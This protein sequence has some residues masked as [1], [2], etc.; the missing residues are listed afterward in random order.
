[1]EISGQPLDIAIVGSGIAG[2]TAAHV[3]SREH[4]VSVFEKN[5]YVG[6]H[7]NTR[8]V[9][10][11]T[12]Q[13]V[14]IDTGFIVCNERNYPCF[15]RF[16]DQLDVERRN[17]DMSFG[18]YCQESRIGYTGP[19]ILD[20]MGQLRNFLNPRFVRML[21]ELRRFNKA[22]REDFRHELLADH[23]LLGYLDNL[24]CSE[25][26]RELYLIPISA[27]IWSSP[28]L[29]M[30]KFPAKT[31]VTFLHH[32]GMLELFG[33]P[34]WQTI[35]GGS[36]A[37]IEAFRERFSGSIHC[38][39]GVTSLQRSEAGVELT[40]QNGD[41]LAFDKVIL[42]AHADQSCTLLSDPSEQERSLLGSWSY[43]K[44]ETVL[45]WDESVMPP[46]KKLWA[47]WNYYR[48]PNHDPSS[49]VPITYYMNRLQGLDSARNYF[50]TLNQTD[51]IDPEKICYRVEYTHPAYDTESVRAQRELRALNGARHTYYCGSYMGYGFHE[52]AVRSALDVTSHFGLSL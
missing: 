48:K 14:D 49:P 3:L 44:N 19:G 38:D 4:N 41:T 52:D 22:A 16:L 43:H 32:H 28:D 10:D 2:I 21:I 37:Y 6:G 31:F 20:F 9:V 30:T 11:G 40:L 12:G 26:F 35:V 36:H 25:E 29:D 45:H 13:E 5:N 17:T 7:T 27:A 50:V 18:Y 15:Y 39:A 33:R 8:R 47:C 42:A 24:K 51:D 46:N 34:Q 23:A 1:M